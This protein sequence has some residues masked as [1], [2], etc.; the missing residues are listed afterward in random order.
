M[1]SGTSFRSDTAR[2]RD[3]AIW[4]TPVTGT[5]GKLE[6][7]EFEEAYVCLANCRKTWRQSAT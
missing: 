1:D 3:D 6:I 5:F 7:I 2:V 4:S